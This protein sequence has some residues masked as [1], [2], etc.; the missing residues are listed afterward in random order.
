VDLGS[1]ASTGLNGP[2]GLAFDPAEDLYVTNYLS[3]TVETFSP[4]GADLGTFA[5]TGM[6]GPAGIA[7]QVSSAAVPEPSSLVMG[8]IGLT[9]ACGTVVRRSHCS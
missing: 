6:N 1:F 5:S 8:L 9:L 7:I 3:N 4:T 2:T